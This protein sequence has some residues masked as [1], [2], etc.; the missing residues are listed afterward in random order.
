MKTHRAFHHPSS[1][2]SS[3]CRVRLVALQLQQGHFA[4]PLE[5]K[6]GLLVVMFSLGLP[7]AV[8]AETP[9]QVYAQQC[10]AETRIKV[11]AFVCDDPRSTLVPMTHA[12]DKEDHPLSV[13]PNADFVKLYDKL[14]KGTDGRCDRPN[15]LNSE[16]DPGSRFRVLVKNKDAFV[17][18]LCRKKGN[19]RDTWGDIAVIQH[20]TKNGATCFY[21]E[22]PRTA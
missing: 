7:F 1:L 8:Q 12:F 22:G 18:A 19:V 13:G 16:C 10:E 21:Q 5:I 9:L 3:R 11:P 15:R 2:I 4:R 6:R 17:V 20:N 14:K